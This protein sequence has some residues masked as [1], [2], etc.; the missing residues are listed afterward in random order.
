MPLSRASTR[1]AAAAASGADN[2][3]TAASRPIV[4]SA[5]ARRAMDAADVVV[6][7]VPSG[8]AA[9]MNAS[10]FPSP[11][12][13]VVVNA[14]SDG[15][16]SFATANDARR[17]AS[18]FGVDIEESAGTRLAA[19]ARRSDVAASNSARS[20]RCAHLERSASTRSNTAL[21]ARKNSKPPP[22]TDASSG[23]ACTKAAARRN[24]GTKTAWCVAR[25]SRQGGHGTR[26]GDGGIEERRRG[27]RTGESVTRRVR[28]ERFARGARAGIRGDGGGGGV[29]GRIGRVRAD[30]AT[31][32]QRRHR[33]RLRQRLRASS[34]KPRE[35]KEERERRANRVWASRRVSRR[36]NHIFQPRVLHRGE[37]RADETGV[38]Q[39][40]THGAQ[41]GVRG[42]AT[43]RHRRRRG[44][45]RERRTDSRRRR[46]RDSKGAR[47]AGG[48]SFS[49]PTTSTA[50]FGGGGGGGGGDE[51]LDGSQRDG[52]DGVV[53]GGVRDVSRDERDERR[54]VS[55]NQRRRA[56][57]DLILRGGGGGG[58]VRGGA[59][60]AARDGSG[61]GGSASAASPA[62]PLVRA[63][64]S[65]EAGNRAALR[66]FAYRKSDVVAAYR[67]P[68]TSASA[69]GCPPPPG[70]RMA[71]SDARSSALH[72]LGGS[73]G[74]GHHAPPPPRM[75]T[76]PTAGSPPPMGSSSRGALVRV[77][78]RR[79]EV[80]ARASTPIAPEA[81]VARRP[82]PLG[83]RPRP[84]PARGREGSRVDVRAAREREVLKDAVRQ[85][86]ERLLRI[87]L[88]GRETAAAVVGETP[89]RHHRDEIAP[90]AH[91]VHVR[92]VFLHGRV[93]RARLA[94]GGLHRRLVRVARRG[95]GANAVHRASAAQRA[96]RFLEESS[97]ERAEGDDG[98]AAGRDLEAPARLRGS[99]VRQQTIDAEF[100][101]KRRG[102]ARVASAAAPAAAASG[103]GGVGGSVARSSSAASRG[104]STADGAP[105]A[106]NVDPSARSRN[107]AARTVAATTG[108]KSSTDAAGKDPDGGAAALQRPRRRA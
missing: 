51:R 20:H 89:R 7:G 85:H 102:L 94:H 101:A 18:V 54:G 77:P 24:A 6:A 93:E 30:G 27:N 48:G 42:D 49:V 23:S 61:S 108:G 74:G 10:Y 52:A 99:S 22:R 63:N 67:S 12:H 29:A 71:A 91:E 87:I 65:T 96:L 62:P 36:E 107:N 106:P 58:G 43:R 95:V 14:S 80:A 2:P 32:D 41:R 17:R 16:N 46:A 81:R 66:G 82:P 104:C 40:A 60:A 37:A 21:C 4:D 26:G 75:P 59:R 90:R 34:R 38:R 92:R 19:R 56:R 76:T 79:R 11:R 105:N 64:A 28:V 25:A 9:A 39:R 70:R 44:G 3:P 50:S 45:G 69:A 53:G 78:R 8:D 31:V 13:S 33:A 68:R 5:D 83:R 55:S 73:G 72:R 84:E 35:A 47:R 98:A 100:G 103:G 1:A 57:L 86:E 97:A 88:G 15:M